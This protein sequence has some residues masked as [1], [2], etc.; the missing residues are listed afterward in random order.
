[1]PAG[2]S[3]TSTHKS[4][5]NDAVVIT[6]GCIFPD[7][8]FDL[9]ASEDPCRPNLVFWDGHRATV[10][11]RVRHGDLWYQAP[12]L[13]PSVGRIMRLP[14]R[15]GRSGSVPKVF[16]EVSALFQQ[17]LG[18]PPDLAQQLTMWKATTWLS[19]Q[20]PS[21][22]ALIALGPNMRRAVDLF[23]LLACGSR[24]ALG[25]TGINRAALVGLPMD[26][27]LTLLISQPALSRS[28]SQLLTAANYRGV[29]VPGKSGAIVDWAGSKAIFLGSTASPSSWS[30]EGLW[31]SL[32]AAETELPPLDEQARARIAPDLQAKFLKFRL[33]WLWKARDAG[34]SVGK[35]PFPESELA[36][37]LSA[38]AW[39]E[40]E[41][42]ET[43]TPLLRGLVEEATARRKL[44][45]EVVVLEV[46][47][48]PA[49]QVPEISVKKITEYLNLRLR[50]RGGHYEYREEEVGW[51]LR[52][53]GFDRRRNG[54]GMV[55][56]F[57][58]DNTPLLH[59]LVRRFG[60]DLPE[61]PGCAV[62]AGPDTI[63]AQES[64]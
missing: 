50:T 44:E 51:I 2:S 33:D 31:I 23:Q 48:E 13:H 26:L 6:A 34:V 38:C 14:D 56:R 45:A 12:E 62:C 60:L 9:A 4:P 1:M 28:L 55:L 11:P 21:P 41:L 18:L 16:A 3:K 64:M 24:R 54:S 7:G 53:H 63:V 25:L 17:Y 36:Q 52:N 20:L 5:T 58:G 40:P 42:M 59:R 43:V 39:Y 27:N 29:H 8:I 46:L 37:S 15:V 47:W 30:G 32:P 49:H 35:R 22:P 10:A 61:L 19:D 57:S